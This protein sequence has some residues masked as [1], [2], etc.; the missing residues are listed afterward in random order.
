MTTTPTSSRSRKL[1]FACL[2]EPQ[3][4]SW[5]DTGVFWEKKDPPAYK[6]WGPGNWRVSLRLGCEPLHPWQAAVQT[7]GPFPRAE[8][9]LIKD[10]DHVYYH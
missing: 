4:M 6:Y 3:M 9:L 10:L 1:V 8:S 5:D 2:F 7:L